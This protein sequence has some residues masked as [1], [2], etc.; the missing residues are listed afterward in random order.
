M[1]CLIFWFGLMFQQEH[2]LYMSNT[3]ISYVDAKK[4]IN[5]KV[6]LFEEDIQ[7]VLLLAH[8]VDIVNEPNHPNLQKYIDEYVW[9]NL[10]IR[11]DGRE[12]REYK[13]IKKSKNYDALIFEY[14]ILNIP[15][16]PKKLSAEAT[17]LMELFPEQTNIVALIVGKTKKTFPLKEFNTRAEITI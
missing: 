7:Q 9:Y 10:K 8:G 14:D 2:P 5:V 17:Y 11:V 16:P 1:W 13:F 4:A 3:V 6:Q 15:N 12:M